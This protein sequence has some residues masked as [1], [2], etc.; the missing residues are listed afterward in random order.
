MTYDWIAKELYI[1]FFNSFLNRLIIYS[2]TT[3]YYS[4]YLVY[5]GVSGG[6]SDSTEVEMTFNLFER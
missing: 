5:N 2:L 4:K 6:I 3:Q 1:I